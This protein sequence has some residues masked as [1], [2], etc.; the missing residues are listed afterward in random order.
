MA[1]AAGH[2]LQGKKILITAGPTWVALD[3]VRVLSNNA[4]GETGIKLA[5]KLQSSGAH[6]TL[7]L[8]PV[9]AS[10]SNTN[11]KIIH[12]SYY[13]E[14]RKKLIDELKRKKYDTIIHSA[15][16]S[17]FRPL[18][19]HT[20]KLSSGKDL[21]VRLTLLPK[22]INDIKRLCGRA[23]LVMF[24]LEVDVSQK[25]LIAR[26]RKAARSAGADIVV[27]N[28]FNPYR[29]FILTQDRALKAKDKT[30]IVNALA[31]LLQ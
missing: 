25:T 11:I 20:G 10:Y 29:A 21:T 30:Q 12:F 5:E 8:G 24:K 31:G 1:Q 14:L 9:A 28:S 6:V 7:F 27:A 26:A 23:Q 22:I 19:K 2:R 18:Y 16:V 13:D 15:A 4:S 3:A 17:D